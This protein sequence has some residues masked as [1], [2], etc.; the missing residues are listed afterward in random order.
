MYI[1]NRQ[2]IGS[3]MTSKKHFYLAKLG[4]VHRTARFVVAFVGISPRLFFFKSHTDW[5][6]HIAHFWRVDPFPKQSVFNTGTILP[7]LVCYGI[8][9]QGNK[10]VV[11]HCWTTTDDCTEVISRWHPW[12]RQN[13]AFTFCSEINLIFK[14]HIPLMFK[15]SLAVISSPSIL[16][17]WEEGSVPCVHSYLPLCFMCAEGLGLR[18]CHQI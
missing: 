7:T 14:F 10:V 4:L 12:R 13:T 5:R 15:L 11:W 1:I 18:G 8:L 2:N 9:T 17:S 16:S 6:S 3:I